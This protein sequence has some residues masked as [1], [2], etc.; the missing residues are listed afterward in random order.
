MQKTTSVMNKNYGKKLISIVAEYTYSS[1][2]GVVCTCIQN[3]LY[4]TT[5]FA[6]ELFILFY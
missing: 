1:M 3:V 4:I 6:F 2:Y 5:V